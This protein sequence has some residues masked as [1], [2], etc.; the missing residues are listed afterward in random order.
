MPTPTDIIAQHLYKKF[1]EEYPKFILYNRRE[2]HYDRHYRTHDTKNTDH[3][4]IFVNGTQITIYTITI[5]QEYD[6]KLI[7]K[8]PTTLNP[9]F[10]TELTNTINNYLHT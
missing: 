5:S 9:H 7:I 1:P 3:I 4:R 6:R 2:H 10:F 8:K